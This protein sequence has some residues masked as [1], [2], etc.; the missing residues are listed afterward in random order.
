MD[1]PVVSEDGTDDVEHDVEL[2]ANELAELAIAAWF[3][4]L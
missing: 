2:E 1:K 4:D 3:Q